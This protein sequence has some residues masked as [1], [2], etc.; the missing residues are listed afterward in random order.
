MTERSSASNALRDHVLTLLISAPDRPG[1]V[2]GV[3]GTLF[4]HEA[5]I[6]EADQYDDH[7]TGMFFQR[8]EFEAAGSRLDA[9]RAAMDALARRLDL[10]WSMRDR[11]DAGAWPCSCRA[12]TTAS[13][14]CSC[15]TDPASSVA[16]SG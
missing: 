6:L 12:R 5:N 11:G 13:T 7:G 3:A 15:D 4:E 14:T 1:L 16:T 2:A 10:T 9:L 8:I